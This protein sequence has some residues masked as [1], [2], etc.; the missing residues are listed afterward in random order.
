MAPPPIVILGNHRSGTT[1]LYRLL[2]ETGRFSVLTAWHV[3][4]WDR[5]ADRARWTPEAEAAD[6][7]ALRARMA[8]LGIA[9]RRGDG[10]PISPELPEE[11]GYILNNAGTG[12]WVRPR[13]LELFRAV[14]A[15]L[16]DGRPVLL[17]NPWDYA[18][19]TWLHRNV[20]GI[21]FVFIHRHPARVVQSAVRALRLLWEERDA[22]TALL[23]RRYVRLWRSPARRRLLQWFTR[24]SGGLDL[25]V[26]AGGVAMA[27]RA[28]V[29]RRG[30]LPE[31]VAV[32]LRYEDLCADPTGTVADLL[33]RLGID[34]GAPPRTAA[35]PSGGPLLPEVA[36]RARWIARR[37]RAYLDAHGYAPLPAALPGPTEPA[38]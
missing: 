28:W 10:V 23:S 13:N 3:I 8:E 20:P 37:N 34:G 4:A 11:Y 2:A 16:D 18:N 6:R 7:E 26:I 14:C 19:F 30:A 32:D 17:K 35:R 12:S 21:R 1:W 29:A 24:R 36:R 9:R 31:G 22:Y 38:P 33:D 15:R 25:R 27:N 5:V